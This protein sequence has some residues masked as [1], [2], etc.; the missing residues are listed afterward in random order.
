LTGKKILAGLRDERISPAK[1]FFPLSC[2]LPLPISPR[3]LA[4][5]REVAM[6]S[7][8]LPAVPAATRLE[9]LEVGAA[10]VIRRFLELLDLPGLFERHLPELPGRQPDLPTC[11]VLAVLLCNLL[12]AR[13]P[14][15]GIAAWAASFVPE[16]LGLLPGQAALLNDDRCGRCLDH[17]YR[18]DRASLFTAITLRVIRVFHC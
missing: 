5:C 8:T 1:I 10:P 13:Q 12:L 9:V 4:L 15:Y 6:P 11:T 3:V 14:L 2:V 16:H 18:A 17:L 7:F